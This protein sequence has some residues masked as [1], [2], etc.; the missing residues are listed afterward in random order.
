MFG[1]YSTTIRPPPTATQDSPP[2]NPYITGVAHEHGLHEGLDVQLEHL[3]PCLLE[4]DLLQV[5]VPRGHGL[6]PGVQAAVLKRP[7]NLAA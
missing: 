3:E 1:N 4:V 7:L 6:V 2:P 5:D